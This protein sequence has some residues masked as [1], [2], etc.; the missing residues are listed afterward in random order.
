MI[1]VGAQRH[2]YNADN[3]VRQIPNFKRPGWAAWKGCPT[4]KMCLQSKVGQPFQA[5]QA[6]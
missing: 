1:E 2:E 3:P 5:A 6:G 4:T